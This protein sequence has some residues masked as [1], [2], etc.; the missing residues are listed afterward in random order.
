LSPQ[1]SNKSDSGG[2]KL[3]LQNAA[4]VEAAYKDMMESI[5]KKIS[6]TP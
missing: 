2:I 6:D 5:S 4:E 1:I 3:S